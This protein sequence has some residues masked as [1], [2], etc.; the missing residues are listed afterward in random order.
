M[1]AFFQVSCLPDLPFSFLLY[2]TSAFFRKCTVTAPTP[3]QISP[4]PFQRYLK[5]VPLFF[6][7]TLL[8]GPFR[9]QHKCRLQSLY[10][11]LCPSPLPQFSSPHWDP[12]HGMFLC[13]ISCSGQCETLISITPCYLSKQK[14]SLELQGSALHSLASLPCCAASEFSFVT[15]S[16]IH[17]GYRPTWCVMTFHWPL[18]SCIQPLPSVPH[19]AWVVRSLA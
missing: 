3:L 10:Y 16:C 6:I 18:L 11:G 17:W 15:Q 8:H 2:F 14:P 4:P 7:L 19:W 9:H 5:K 1:V 12:G 13:L